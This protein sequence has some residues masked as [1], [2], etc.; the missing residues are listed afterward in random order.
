MTYTKEIK[1]SIVKYRRPVAIT[2]AVLI[3]LAVLFWIFRRLEKR[4]GGSTR[5]DKQ[6]LDD[7]GDVTEAFIA[8]DILQYV[9]RIHLYLVDNYD[10]P[11]LFSDSERCEVFKSLNQLNVNELIAVAN[12][13]ENTYNQT[14][15]NVIDNI[16]F[17][18]CASD[19]FKLKSKHQIQILKNTLRD[20]NI[21]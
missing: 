2:I 5:N 4:S 14:L 17:H 13:Y 8:N 9:D 12:T 3:G 19:L 15:R 10:G 20:N 18:G 7:G 11:G 21:N 1:D 16:T 6:Y